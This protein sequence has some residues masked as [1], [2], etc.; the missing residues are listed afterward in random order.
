MIECV[1][2]SE[3]NTQFNIDSQELDINNANGF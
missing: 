3:I 2:I 1:D